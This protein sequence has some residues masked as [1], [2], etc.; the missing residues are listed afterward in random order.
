[1]AI[2]KTTHVLKNTK[3]NNQPLPTTGTTLGEPLVNLYNG[4]LY[5]SGVTGGNYVQSDNNSGYFEVGSNLYDLK[6]RNKIVGY[7]GLTGSSL[8]NTF[9]S[10]TSTGFVVAPISGISGIDTYVTGF[11]YTSN[12]NTLTIGR[13]QNKNDL[14]VVL[15]AFTDVLLFGTTEVNGNLNVTG[16]TTLNNLTIT[17]TGYY[18]NIATGSSYNEIVNYS[19]LTSYTQ[20]NDIYVTGGTSTGSTINL[21]DATIDLTY[22]N[23]VNTGL[24]TL[25]YKDTFSTGG[26]FDNITSYITVDKN[27]GTN[28]TIDMGGA[29]GLPTTDDRTIEVNTDFNW[30]QLMDVVQAPISGGPRTFMD[31]III[32]GGSLD[33][34]SSLNITGLSV[35]TETVS[36][37][38][39]KEIVNVEYLTGFSSTND[40]YVTGATYTGSSNSNSGTTFELL[41]HGTPLNGPYFIYGTDVYT[42][43]ATYNSGTTSIDF[44]R[45]DGETYSANLSS[46]VSVDTYVTGFTYNSSNNSLTISQNQGQSGL[47]EYI[48]SFSGLSVGNLTSGQVVYAGASG[49]LKTDGTGEFAY[50]DSTNT[51]TIGSSPNFGKLVVNNDLNAGASTFGQGGVVIGSGGSFGPS[52]TT[53]GIGDLTIHGNLIVFGTGTTIAT[54]ELYVEDPQITLNYNPTGDTTF[55][56]VGSGIKIQDGNGII[57]GDSYFTI[58]QMDTFIGNTGDNIITPGEY[59]G[60]TGDTNRA[61]V[62]QLNDIVL[63]NTNYNNGAPDGGRVLVSGDVLDGGNY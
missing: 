8:D 4:I 29:T 39:P 28:Y 45:N 62:T 33:V 16:D 57:S 21:A 34:T 49:Q 13:N 25:N 60:S 58:G 17:G 1:M 56:S 43:S 37:T 44:T 7:Q 31:Q 53:A 19:T 46:F 15:S 5:F 55:T 54:N 3:E 9:L 42:T 20:S 30:I 10:G 63:R 12:D 32:S 52:G 18:N 36:G 61:W 35:Y 41:Y 2:R 59:S 22:I 38:D 50:D 40:V 26:T 11:T 48:N 23:G 14:P 6:L 24:Y 27:D 51:L 47:T